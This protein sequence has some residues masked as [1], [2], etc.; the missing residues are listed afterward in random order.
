M[1]AAN[2]DRLVR[3]ITAVINEIQQIQSR[4]AGTGEPPSQLELHELQR[5]GRHYSD[6]VEQLIN[7]QDGTNPND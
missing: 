7:L 2:K 5:L 4:I 6:L 3:E 1:H